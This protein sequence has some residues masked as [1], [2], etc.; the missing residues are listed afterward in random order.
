MRNFV[1]VFLLS[2][3]ITSFSIAAEKI[4][5]IDIQKVVQESVA[6]KEAQQILEKQARIAQQEVQAKAQ[7]KG[8]EEAQALAVQKQQELMQKRQELIEKFMKKVQNTLEK[9][10]K[11]NG[12]KL[13]FDKQ[14][15]LYSKDIYDKTDEFIKFFNKEYSKGEKLK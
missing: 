12:Y 10:S 11:E 1:S 3:F 4:A 6:G 7:Q 13:V 5:V 15:I 2:V 8:Q 9:F 14:S